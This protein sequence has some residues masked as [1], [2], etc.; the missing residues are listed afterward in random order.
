MACDIRSVLTLSA[1]EKSKAEIGWLGEFPIVMPEHDDAFYKEQFKKLSTPDERIYERII[2]GI[3][4][5]TVSS[6]LDSE[7]V[8]ERISNNQRLLRENL[9][10]DIAE[11]NSCFHAGA[12]KA[13]A[14]MAGAILEA[15]LID[16][17]S[18]IEE[19]NYFQ[20]T[21]RVPNIDE[22]TGKQKTNEDGA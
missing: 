17:L 7:L 15:F 13:A 19:V 8:K 16:W 10:L 20:C 5:N 14:L 1:G 2:E 22:A 3:Q 4:S 21:K 6:I 11:L 12:Y 9:K 18:E